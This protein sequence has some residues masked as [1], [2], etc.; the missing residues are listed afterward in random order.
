[1]GDWLRD[2]LSWL[3]TQDIPTDDE[4]RAALTRWVPEYGSRAAGVEQAA[5][6]VSYG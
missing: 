3:N 6:R 1:V 4:V 5:P 2:L